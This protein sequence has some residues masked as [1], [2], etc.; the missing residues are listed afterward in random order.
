M[1]SN[2]ISLVRHLICFPFASAGLFRVSCWFDMSYQFLGCHRLTS[3]CLLS[4]S[5]FLRSSLLAPV[6]GIAR[7]RRA[8]ASDL[9]TFPSPTALCRES[10]PNKCVSRIGAQR[11]TRC[12]SHVVHESVRVTDACVAAATRAQRSAAAIGAGDVDLTAALTL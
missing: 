8:S 2:P 12:S 7:R 4:C 10:F 1:G 9:Q 6:P 5:L 3:A 11:L